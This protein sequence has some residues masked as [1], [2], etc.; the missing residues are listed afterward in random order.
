M[1]EYNNVRNVF[2]CRC[3][4]LTHGGTLTYTIQWLAVQACGRCKGSRL[5][6]PTMMTTAIIL[7]FV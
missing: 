7:Y 2:T 3:M 5:K 4:I 6:T 1:I